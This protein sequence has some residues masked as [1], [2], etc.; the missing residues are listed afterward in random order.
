[1]STRKA[2]ATAVLA[3]SAALGMT[4]APAQA[5]VEDYTGW[6]IFFIP[7]QDDEV[8]TSGASIRQHVQKDRRVLAVLMTDGGGAIACSQMGLTRETCV[9]RRDAEFVKAVRALGAVPKIAPNRGRDAGLTDAQANTIVRSYARFPGVRIKGHSDVCDWNTDHLTIGRAIRRYK[10]EHPAQKVDARFY[11][12]FRYAAQCNQSGPLKWGAKTGPNHPPM[13][14]WP[15]V[16]MTHAQMGY[17]VSAGYPVG[18]VGRKSM[19][20]DLTAIQNG[21]QTSWVHR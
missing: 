12:N 4:A 18:S 11:T 3:A 15:D 8:L 10:T 14:A 13:G 2:V 7:H 16:T 6:T 5:A 9:A 1:M 20:E 17:P 21:S 19:P